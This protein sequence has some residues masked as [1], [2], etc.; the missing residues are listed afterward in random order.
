MSDE[1]RYETHRHAPGI[2]I[3]KL[4]GIMDGSKFGE[5]VQKRIDFVNQFDDP[6]YV[7]VYDMLEV[8][9]VD[10]PTINAGRVI[11]QSDQ[12]AL[13][14]IIVGGPPV[15]RTFAKILDK[16]LMGKSK[17]KFVETMEAGLKLAQEIL[18]NHPK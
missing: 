2:Y 16:G 1:L 11:R 12:R 7:I 9:S 3:G 15:I 17:F 18:T 8:T 5:A 13:A 10:R 4:W 6:V 14:M